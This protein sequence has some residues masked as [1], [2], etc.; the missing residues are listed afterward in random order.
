MITTEY[1]LDDINQGYEDMHAGDQHSRRDPVL[2][3]DP[4]MVVSREPGRG[5]ASGRPSVMREA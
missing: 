1:S 3:R 2:I 5:P 4:T